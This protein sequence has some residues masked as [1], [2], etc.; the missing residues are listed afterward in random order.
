[1]LLTAGCADDIVDN[2]PQNTEGEGPA[3]VEIGDIDD[4]TS[5]GSYALLAKTGITNVTGSLVTG[6]DVGL[7]PAAASFITGFA[8]VADPT[9]VFSTSVSVV[10][11]AQV[12]AADYADP[13]PSNLTTAILAMEASYIDA[14][15]R[16]QPDELNLADGNLGGLT[17]APGLYTWGSSVTI[18]T[19][20]TLSGAAG[21][22]WILQVSNDL[23]LAAAKSVLLS[24]GARAENV[25]WQVAG[26][27]TIREN[28]H[29][30]GVIL[31]KTGITLQTNASLHGRALAQ[32]M[33]ALDDNV[34]TA[35]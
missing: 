22:V 32:T 4:S 23:D 2:N 35:P 26:A 11:P 25:F 29:F 31:S 5:A 34:I 8:L 33:I 28:A 21:D 27:V 18:P 24:G 19:D 9:N 7:S 1:M 20:L 15:S 12:F 30:E 10:P 13:T 16:T 6:G 17:L 3:H 14:A